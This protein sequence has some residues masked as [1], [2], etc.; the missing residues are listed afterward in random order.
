MDILSVRIR[1]EVSHFRA[2]PPTAKILLAS[3]VLRSVAHP[4]ISLFAGAYIWHIKSDPVYL[5]TYYIANFAV[6]PVIFILNKAL[7]T[8]IP[9]RMLY[10]IGTVLTG[11]SALMVV[12]FRSQTLFAYAFY[13]LLYGCGNGIYWANRN[14]LALRHI[15][16]S[17]RSYYTGLYF[18]LT[19][20]ANVAIPALA[21]W[22][23]VLGVPLG[24]FASAQIG[25]Q[26]LMVIAFGI[27]IISGSIVGT[28]N[29]ET[30]TFRSTH[31][32]P[33]S[34]NWK[35]NAR[36]LSVAV[37]AVDAQLYILPTILILTALGNEGMLGT[38]MSAMAV[39]TAVSVYVFGR[40][41]KQMHF[42]TTLKGFIL[43]FVIAGMPLMTGINAFSVLW[44]V[45]IT[46]LTDTLL[47]TANEPVLMDMQDA[48]A[49]TTGQTHTDL[50]IDREWFINI[51]R[52][53]TL[54]IVVLLGLWNPA[55]AI[56]MSAAVVSLAALFITW[57]VHLPT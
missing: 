16:S 22:M 51:G 9:M 52:V 55:Y 29:L 39:I 20:I 14:F 1:K 44:Y 26:I 34:D 57:G 23:I 5:S 31:P 15:P 35:R 12:F 27:L 50:I 25:Y 56:Q 43:L 49:S 8:R 17:I 45:A 41:Q 7:L 2:I 37:G 10:G 32:K 11:V 38:I 24:L 21:G 40:K 4:L 42:L 54:T 47:W 30:P 36:L 13:G 6:L 3:F 48:E 19:T 46:T 18:S 53:G 28:T 33:F